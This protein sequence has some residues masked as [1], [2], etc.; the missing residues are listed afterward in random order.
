LLK[1]L[2]FDHRD[3]WIY[4]ISALQKQILYRSLIIEMSSIRASSDAMK[5]KTIHD[6][7]KRIIKNESLYTFFSQQGENRDV[8]KLAYEDLLFIAETKVMLALKKMFV[9][10]INSKYWTTD[11]IPKPLYEFVLK[12]LN[13]MT[14]IPIMDAMVTILLKQTPFPEYSPKGGVNIHTIG[15]IFVNTNIIEPE[16]INNDRL[17]ILDIIP[18]RVHETKASFIEKYKASTIHYKSV[19]ST[20]LSEIE[21]LLS[22]VVGEPVPFRQGPVMVQLHFRKRPQF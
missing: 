22:T 11:L 18:C 17:C 20:Q 9:T 4:S 15:C 10:S 6:A 14:A 7:L 16:Y 2:G 1:A 5:W 13:G 12:E 21:F 3:A 19:S 8:N